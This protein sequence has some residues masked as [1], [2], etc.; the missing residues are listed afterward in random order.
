M[1][2]EERND[3]G[4]LGLDFQI[5]L[6]AQFINDNK[7]ANSIM[8]IVDP[9][10]F[11][12]PYIRNIAAIIRDGFINDNAIPD[13]NSLEF[14][15]IE[16]IPNEMTR[17]LTLEQLKKIK[18][19]DLNDSEK[20]QK[21]ASNFCK[22]QE[23]NKAISQ[24]QAIINKGGDGDYEQCATLLR[25]ALDHGESTDNGISVFENIESV[26]ADD[27]RKTV[28]T[29]INGL[30]EVMNGGLGKGELGI[31]LAALGVGKT[32]LATKIANT[33]KNNGLN[34]LQIFFEDS[35]KDIQ[36]KHLA[37]WSG[38][39]LNTLSAHKDELRELVTRKD[40]EPGYL[41]LKRFNSDGTTMPMIKKY[42]L[43]QIASGFRPDVIL[44]DY[45]DCVQPSKHYDDVN[46]AEG[47]IMRQYE[48]MLN[49][50]N[51]AGW[52]CTQGNRSAIKS[53]VVDTDQ[54]G[55]S[56]KKAQIGHF[57]LSIA[58]TIPQKDDNLA[59]IA[60][61]KSRFGR[62]GLIFENIKFDNSRIQIDMDDSILGKKRSVV[63]D[64]KEIN[65]QKNITA[66][67]EALKAR[68]NAL[69]N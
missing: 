18:S 10:Y 5:R 35:P 8:D 15:L 62:D 29:G 67:F 69:T 12:D 58:R 6:I 27:F 16:A 20:I 14:R 55:G 40:N 31:I 61:L 56:I 68:K 4:Y 53:E 64:E 57:I 52:A 21:M 24:I 46:A 66:A 60:V 44:I 22:Q 17:N 39:E 32:T 51:I 33:A 54:M 65:Q 59:T 37:C 43:K 30:D 34:A 7:F 49:E 11:K 38:H 45:I 48:T 23:L 42:V 41:K 3:L 13:I 2:V 47:S 26:L 25:K 1:N 19:A 36:R 63:I 50:L 28:P 9:N